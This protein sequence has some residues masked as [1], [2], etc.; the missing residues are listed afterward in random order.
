MFL[1]K[2]TPKHNLLFASMYFMR[3]CLLFSKDVLRG[4]L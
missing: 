1:I 4:L 3:P 2:T